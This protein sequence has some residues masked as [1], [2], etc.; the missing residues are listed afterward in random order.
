MRAGEADLLD[1]DGALL[2]AAGRGDTRHGGDGSIENRD[3]GS[4]CR[5]D[6]SGEGPPTT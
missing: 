1:G 3:A 4:A 5:V 6:L 2:P